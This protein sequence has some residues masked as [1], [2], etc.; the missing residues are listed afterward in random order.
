MYLGVGLPLLAAINGV[1]QG[2]DSGGVDIGGAGQRNIRAVGGLGGV[3]LG[4]RQRHV[5]V[6]RG[7]SAIRVG[8]QTVSAQRLRLSRPPPRWMTFTI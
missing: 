5:R 2:G 8:H 6:K 4:G 3:V 7:N 1:R